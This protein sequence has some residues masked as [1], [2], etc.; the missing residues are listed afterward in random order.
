VQAGMRHRKKYTLTILIAPVVAWRIT[1]LAI[2]QHHTFAACNA[3]MVSSIEVD[4]IT[5]F[6]LLRHECRINAPNNH[7]KN[8]NLAPRK[9][10][11][12]PL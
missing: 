12:S 4:K 9:G 6:Y 3:D 1:P 11:F 7:P 2:G 5:L 10:S 8:T